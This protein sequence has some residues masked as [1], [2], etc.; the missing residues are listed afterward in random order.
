MAIFPK[1]V[2]WLQWVLPVFLGF[3][4]FLIPGSGNPGWAGVLMIFVVP[5]MFVLLLIPPIISVCIRANRTAGMAGTPYSF[6]MLALLVLLLVPPLAIDGAS[7]VAAYPSVFG[8]LG[9][10]PAA[11]GVL[12]AVIM[13]ACSV[14]WVTCLVLAA[15]PSRNA[16][17]AVTVETPPNAPVA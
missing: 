8:N 13:S 17:K 3:W 1:T 10:S 7:D 11:E 6:A 14:L 2:F 9:M 5:V 15:F 4:W 12:I 16:E